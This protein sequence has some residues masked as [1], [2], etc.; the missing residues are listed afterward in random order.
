MQESRLTPIII[1]EPIW[2]ATGFVDDDI[3]RK[4]DSYSHVINAVGGYDSA[5]ITMTMR[6]IDAEDW[7]A[8]G[9]GRHV[10]FYNHALVKKWEGFVNEIRIGVGALAA[11]Q[12]PMMD[13]V[14]RTAVVYQTVR[15]N[16]NPPIGGQKA[17]T[18]QGNNTDSQTKFGILESALNGGEATETRAES[19]RDT[20]LAERGWPQSNKDINFSGGG[21]ITVELSCLGYYHLLSKYTYQQIVNSGETNISTKIQNVLTADP[22]SRF[23]SDYSQIETNTT[24]INQFENEARDAWTVI[25]NAVVIGDGSG[26]RTLF[27]IYNDRKAKYETIPSS[28][29][30]QTSLNAQRQQV[31][32]LAGSW[33]LPWDVRPGLWLTINDFLIGQV[34]PSELR[35]DQRNI[36]I[37][38]VTFT[39]PYGLSINGVQVETLPQ[40][41]AQ[42]GLGSI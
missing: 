4:A 15:Y 31:E 26:N 25:Q 20:F 10:E 37:E 34:Q 3:A 5:S 35:R 19:I 41:L 6:K 8:N 1:S 11:S 23:S 30:L 29:A 36:F 2:N 24:Q 28:I 22:S 9:L 33:V 12:G 16:T 27:G 39:A 7:F 38:R 40:L 14:N 18:E 13:I 32:T 17:T 21:N 42:Y